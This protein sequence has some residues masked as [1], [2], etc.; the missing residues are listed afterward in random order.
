MS[1]FMEYERLRR[2]DKN[3]FS[4]MT[5]SQREVLEAD[6]AYARMARRRFWYRLWAMI[7]QKPYRLWNLKALSPQWVGARYSIGVHLVPL[8]VIQGSEGKENAFDR[9]FHPLHDKQSRSRWVAIALARWQGQSLPPVELIRVD[10]GRSPIYFVR[11]GHHRISVARAYGQREIE[12]N[13]IVWQ[14][15]VPAPWSE[16]QPSPVTAVTAP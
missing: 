12:A 10:D 5:H 4:R 11:D 16:W 14:L 8:T 2:N 3:D 13:V 6:D 15:N 9:G 1:Y 7:R